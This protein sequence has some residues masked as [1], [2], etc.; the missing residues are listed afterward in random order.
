MD[1]GEILTFLTDEQGKVLASLSP[2]CSTWDEAECLKGQ[3]EFALQVPVWIEREERVS[4]PPGQKS[5]IG[6]Q[7]YMVTESF[8]YAIGPMMDVESAARLKLRLEAL[9]WKYI[10]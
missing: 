5:S 9:P 10:G 3:L 7:H 4:Q 2:P 6:V 8:K 1:D